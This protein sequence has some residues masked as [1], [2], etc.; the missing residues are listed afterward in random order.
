M[1]NSRFLGAAALVCLTIGLTACASEEPRG[2]RGGERGERGGPGPRGGPDA[3]QRPS[4][5]ISPAGQ[6]FHA[7]A[8]APYPVAA[9]F[10]QA[11]RDH[12]GKITREE[13]RADF[14]AYFHVLDANHDGVIDGFEIADYEQK[15]APEILS[16][17]DRPGLAG[18]GQRAQGPGGRDGQGPGGGR[19]GPGSGRRGGGG[20]GGPG[21]AGPAGGAARLQLQGAAAYSLFNVSEPIS[22]ADTDFDGKV[23]L[24]EFLAAADRRFD[25]LDS[26]G[27]GYLTLGGLPRTPQQIALE[28]R[29][30]QAR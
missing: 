3:G 2:P 21:P 19:G 7:S 5:F 13:F 16:D 26:K 4:L 23:T 25:M 18:P 6:P 27:L 10:E 1:T 17:L 24:K 28:G 30:P 9:W 14:E 11:D 15:I 8:G 22:G 20:G 29:R 12:D